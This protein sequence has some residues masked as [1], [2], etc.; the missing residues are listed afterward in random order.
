MLDRVVIEP[1]PETLQRSDTHETED[2]Q[3]PKEVKYITQI[4]QLVKGLSLDADNDVTPE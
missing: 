2:A 3:L 4:T 1:Q